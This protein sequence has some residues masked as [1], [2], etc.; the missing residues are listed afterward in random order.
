MLSQSSCGANTNTVILLFLEIKFS[1]PENLGKYVILIKL[2]KEHANLNA[3]LIKSV[4][5]HNCIM[6]EWI[7][8]TALIFGTVLN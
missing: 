2:L 1:F 3:I 4:S 7:N 8:L 5:L 6:P